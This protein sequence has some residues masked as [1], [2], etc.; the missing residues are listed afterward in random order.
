LNGLNDLNGV[1]P[2]LT[3]ASCLKPRAY[4][5]ESRSCFGPTRAA[6]SVV[7]SSPGFGGLNQPLGI[8]VVMLIFSRRVF[9]SR[10]RL[11]PDRG[12][13][14]RSSGEEGKVSLSAKIRKPGP[15]HAV[16][17]AR[18][19]NPSRSG[20]PIGKQPAGLSRQTRRISMKQDARR[21]L[22]RRNRQK[23]RLAMK[24]YTAEKKSKESGSVKIEN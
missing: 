12:G 20:I 14:R 8:L 5:I 23:K 1:I 18:D 22:H 13:S 9:A 15:S 11:E 7:C 21:N 16:T 3:R 10:K 4:L 17:A 19:S 6:S 2:T 24:K